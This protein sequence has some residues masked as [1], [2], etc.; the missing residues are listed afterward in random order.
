MKHFFEKYEE[1]VKQGRKIQQSKKDLIN[2][3]VAKLQEGTDNG[4]IEF[5]DETSYPNF[6]DD[7]LG[8]YDSVVKARVNNGTLELATAND[9]DIWFD[10]E[11]YGE[12][13]LDDFVAILCH[14]FI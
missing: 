5:T 6:F 14:Y 12:L 3:M 11:A 4:Y 13:D 8:E 2:D 10:H 9:I 1:L 7:T